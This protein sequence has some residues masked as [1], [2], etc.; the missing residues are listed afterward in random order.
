MIMFE[1]FC[2]PALY[3]AVSAV[4]AIYTSGRSTGVVVDIGH[5]ATHAV[6]IYEGVALPHAMLSTNV[7]GKSI[8]DYIAQA[9][10]DR[11]NVFPPAIANRIAQGVTEKMCYVALDLDADL[12]TSWD[13]NYEAS[14]SHV[15]VSVGRERFCGPEGLFQPSFLGQDADGVHIMTYKSIMM[16]EADVRNDLMGQI[17]MTGGTSML[18]GLVQRMSKEMNALSSTVSAVNVLALSGRHHATWIGGSILSS[19]SAFREEWIAKE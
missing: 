9:L 18:S 10:R 4:L 15:G 14:T 13:I 16:C 2:V 19:R 6:P 12:N 8:I 5:S 11:G 17:L 7:A 3:V 1:T